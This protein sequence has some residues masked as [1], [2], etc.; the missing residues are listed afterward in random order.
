MRGQH[1]TAELTGFK[2]GAGARSAVLGRAS[3]AQP[4]SVKR[5]GLHRLLRERRRLPRDALIKLDVGLG[6]A[7]EVPAGHR[8]EI[9]VP[10]GRSAG[11][12]D[13]RRQLWR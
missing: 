8:P 7:E 12:G 9:I 5:E 2:S 6:L 13:W 4:A 10:G 3:T 11:G 1:R